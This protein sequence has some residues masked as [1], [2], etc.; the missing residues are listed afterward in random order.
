MAPLNTDDFRA[1]ARR[2]LPK[3]L[4]DYIDRGTEDEVSL[5]RIRASL[6]GIR[7]RPRILNGDCPA[8]LETALLGRSRPTPL[9]IAPTALAG[10]VADRGETK[11]ARAASRF[12]IPFTVS[13]QSVEPIEDIRRGAPRPSCGSSF[14]SGR[15][16]P[17]R[18]ICCTG[19]RLAI[20][21]RWC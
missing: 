16:A 8:S 19:S 9:V 3:G 13:T 6:D 10:M 15:T 12:G 1:A 5:S 18:P 14:T 2:R 21:I 7:L 11:L 4:F 17:A 20:A